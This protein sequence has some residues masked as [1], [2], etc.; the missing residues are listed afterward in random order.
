MNSELIVR[1][2]TLDR[3]VVTFDGVEA[4]VPFVSPL[5]EEDLAELRWYLESYTASYTAD[6][7]DGRAQRLKDQLKNWG[8]ALYRSVFQGDTIERFIDFRNL[9]ESGRVVTVQASHPVLLSLPWELLHTPQGGYLFNE[10]PR[11][12]IRRNLAKTGGRSLQKIKPKDRLR[13]LFVVSRPAGAGFLDP[14]LE[15]KA[16][17]EALASE[18]I[19]RVDV[20]FLRPATLQKL[21]DRLEREPAIDILHFDGHGVFDTDGKLREQVKQTLPPQF[22]GMKAEQSDGVGKNVGYLL[23]EDEAGKK[24]FVD[25]DRLGELLHQQQI[26]LVV[27]SACQ[28]STVAGEDAFGSVAARLTQTGIPAILA[29][30][31]SVLITTTHNLFAEFYKQLAMG[32]GIGEALDNA[33]RRLLSNPLRGERSRGMTRVALNLEDWFVPTLYQATRDVPLLAES[34]ALAPQPP[35][36]GGLPTQSSNSGSLSSQSPPEM[37]DLGGGSAV[38]SNLPP[39][40]EVGFFGRTRELWAIERAFVQGTRRF[41]L[42][43]FGGQGKTA[44][45]QES[46]RWLQKTGMFDRVCFVDYAQ[47]QGVDAVSLAVTTLATVLGQNLIDE[48]AATAALKQTRTLIILDNLESLESEPLRE[49]LD[50]AK[51][52][53]EAGGSRLLLT[54][55]SPD[56]RHA[57]YAT[58]GTRR[59]LALALPG[60]G[61]VA[62][63]DDALEY[64]RSLMALSAGLQPMEPLKRHGVIELC[65]LVEFHPL[66]LAL[67]ARQLQTR[68]VAEVGN[69]L[70]RLL[71]ET[72]DL[73]ENRILI[74]SLRLSLERLDVGVREWLPRLGVFQSGALEP[75]LLSVTEVEEPTWQT[76]RQQLEAKGLIQV[77]WLP[78]VGVP[79]LKFHPTLAPALWSEVSAEMQQELLSR[80]RR[81]YYELSDYLYQKDTPNPDIARA[82][83]RRELSNL[84][85]AVKGA[86]AAEEEWALKFV[87]SLSLF[88]NVF[89]LNRDRAAIS[90][91]ASSLT[92]T[93]GSQS[94]YLS[95][96]NE[97]EQLLNAGRTE[98]ALQKFEQILAELGSQPS[99]ERCLTLGRLG[100]CLAAQRQLSAAAQ[101]YR[102][103]LVELNHLELSDS[104]NREI[105]LAQ[106]DLA[107]VLRGIGDYAGAKVAYDAGLVIARGQDDL[108][109]VGVI[110]GQFGTLALVQG[111]LT[112]AVQGYQEA[113][114]IF[115]RLHE[116]ASEAGAWHQL[117]IAYQR[118]QQWQAAEQAYRRSAELKE[119][120]GNR[121]GAAGSWSH[122][123]I[124]TA[125]MGNLLD[126]EAWFRKALNTFQSEG[127]LVNASTIRSY[128]ARLLCQQHN[129]PLKTLPDR[130]PEAHQLAEEALAIQQTIDPAAAEIWKTYNILADISDAQQQPDQAQAYCRLARQSKAAFARTRYELQKF[131]P[132]IA[133]VVAAVTDA[134]VQQEVEEALEDAEQRGFQNLVAAIRQIWEGDRDEDAL[135]AS[136]DLE[137][138]IVVMAILE[139]I[140]V[141]Q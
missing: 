140:E 59:H 107:T 24:V 45:A 12:S 57:D 68:R 131:A 129:S 18:G 69:A 138:A 126:A 14:R 3:V 15:P 41:T 119:S 112:E 75:V 13:L 63:P 104:V 79:Y 8:E 62:Y 105:G 109:Q 61:S 26:G 37:G 35:K 42:H 6:I 120:L 49:L 71:A 97:A 74:A 64:V 76:V 139:A 78:E 94:W 2:A 90:Q 52:W 85:F 93:V 16:V 80:H 91:Q 38:K 39:P 122:L 137:D 25:A 4:E 72:Q 23:F 50:T 84:M 10:K 60:L 51:E 54:T 21:C 70:E 44:L 127:D 83:A 20:E 30:P 7:D 92:I 103:E 114:A 118:S 28:S 132:L 135:C 130:I 65:E 125:S 106:S 136:L 29:M 9:R 27:L 115:Q 73:S 124:V 36:I 82:I 123:A 133:G 81:R 100:R 111:N 101:R 34:L 128:L 33:R 141:A 116:P 110:E 5:S 117:G 121:L 98:A 134:A 47:F 56:F 55:R 96:T 86:I 19:D 48:N 1:F 66:S 43:G 89:G 77:E 87:T 53:S 58:E 31:Y 46:G 113:L 22:A 99:Y 11:I 32:K 67:V 102:E 108:R 88:L 40:R 17:M 95:C